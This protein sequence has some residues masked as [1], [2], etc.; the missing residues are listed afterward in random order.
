[1]ARTASHRSHSCR[2]NIVTCTIPISDFGVI[3]ELCA[4]A[5]RGLGPPRALYITYGA[6]SET[7]IMKDRKDRV[8]SVG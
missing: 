3:V 6:D 4:V 8:N 7:R 2:E 1:M 5:Q